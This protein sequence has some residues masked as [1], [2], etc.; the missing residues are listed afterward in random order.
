MRRRDFLKAAGATTLALAAPG[1]LHATAGSAGHERVFV[2]VE[3]AGGNDGLNTVV[4]FADSAYRRL[5]PRLAV[6][7]DDVIRLDD[8]LGLSS[9][10]APLAEAW[11][12]GELAVALGVGYPRPNRSHFRSIEIWE[13]GS[14]GDEVLTRG[15][16]ARLER[17]ARSPHGTELEGLTLGRGG[18]GPLAGTRSLAVAEPERFVRRARRVRAAPSMRAAGALGHVLSVQADVADAA[19]DLSRHLAKAP[20][21]GVDFPAGALGRDLRTAARLLA[22]GL[23]VPVIKVTQRGYD[24][25]ANQAAVHRRLLDELGGSL[26]AFRQAM[27]RAGLWDRVLLMTYSEFGR[28]AGENG[29]GGTDHGTAAPQFLLGGRVRGGLVGSQPRLDELSSG[30][31][32]HSLSHRSLYATVARRWWE[33]PAS[34]VP[35]TEAPLD[36]VR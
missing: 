36:L 8:R 35:F 19:A 21:L 3:L 22:G 17:D 18:L 11:A 32:R 9:R 10:L 29:S 23:S 4:P 1:V 7:A 5:R 15:W 31:L 27:T 13:T 33:L 34:A 26:A 30:D 6:P 25:H 24:T 12:A 14:D 20:P 16:I 28:R 2:L